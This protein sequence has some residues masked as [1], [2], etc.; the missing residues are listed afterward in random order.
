MRGKSYMALGAIAMG[1]AGSTPNPELFEKYLGMRYAVSYTHLDVY[2][3][4]A[5]DSA[6]ASQPVRYDRDAASSKPSVTDT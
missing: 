4:Q 3:R 5:Q 1:I 6:S 2:K